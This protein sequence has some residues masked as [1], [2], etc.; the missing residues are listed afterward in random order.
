MRQDGFGTGLELSRRRI[1][2]NRNRNTNAQKTFLFY[3][4]VCVHILGLHGHENDIHQNNIWPF[5]YHKNSHS[6]IDVN[7]NLTMNIF[8]YPWREHHI[9]HEPNCIHPKE[10]ILSFT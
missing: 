8:Y 4:G 7:T 1:C 5:L 9:V 2:A 3:F 10:F 6:I